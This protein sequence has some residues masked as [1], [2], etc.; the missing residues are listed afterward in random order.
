[1]IVTPEEY[2]ESNQE[3]DGEFVKL[4]NSQFESC[5]AKRVKPKRSAKTI[6]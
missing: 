4:K 6:R 5:K 2:N 3:F 1:M